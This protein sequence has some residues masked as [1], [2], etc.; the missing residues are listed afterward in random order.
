[1]AAVRSWR[2]KRCVK[3]ARSAEEITALD[4]TGTII[5]WGGCTRGLTTFYREISS[6]CQEAMDYEPG[7][8]LRVMRLAFAS[9]QHGQ[10][11]RVAWAGG[12]TV[13]PAD[14]FEAPRRLP[15]WR[16][17]AKSGRTGARYQS[18]MDGAQTLNDGPQATLIDKLIALAR[19]LSTHHPTQPPRPG[20]EFPGPCLTRTP[21][22]RHA[23][24][25][26]APPL[27][28]ALGCPRRAGTPCGGAKKTGRR[29]TNGSAVLG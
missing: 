23:R 28:I 6:C 19:Y 26:C 20:A 22:P 24:C 2:A 29:R 12:Q 15:A 17:I 27:D 14:S 10:V 18:F 3:L 1:M 5:G 11:N 4:P 16:G 7:Q 8:S 25:R 13:P 21:N 9:A